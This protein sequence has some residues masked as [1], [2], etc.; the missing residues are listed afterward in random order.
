MAFPFLPAA[1]GAGTSLLSGL[2][3]GGQ[4]EN[5]YAKQLWQM[6]MGQYT[7]AT[8]EHVTAPIVQ[9]GE[10]E[11]VGIKKWFGSNLP[12]GTASGLELANLM[13]SGA[14]TQRAVGQ[15]SSQ[16]KQGLLQ[17]LM[18]LS[19]Q[20]QPGKTGTQ[21]GLENLFGTGGDLSRIW[22]MKELGLFK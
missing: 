12:A 7:G 20:M 10:R 1:V 19:G 11:R 5:P 16:Y 21:T 22:F 17:M 14:G 6:L 4:K 8:P 9:A 15:A 2:F 3:G 13:R 18:G